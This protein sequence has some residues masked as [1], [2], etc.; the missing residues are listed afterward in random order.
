[1]QTPSRVRVLAR[2]LLLS[3]TEARMAKRIE[4]E[5][6]AL[7]ATTDEVEFV[8]YGAGKSS[9]S[10]SEE[11][12]AA[13]VTVRARIGD[14][15][16]TAS[17]PRLQGRFLFALL[18]DLKPDLCLELG[19][20]LGVST[21]YMTSALKLNDRGFA[22]SIEGAES[23]AVEARALMGRLALDRVEIDVGRFVDVLPGV[24]DG[25]RFDFA[26]V[27]GHHDE[28][29][30]IGYFSQ[31]T[32]AMTASG[33]MLFDDIAW[34]DGMR[35][36]WKAIRTDSAVADSWEYRGMGLVTLHA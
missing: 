33:V 22:Y 5:R 14:V 29:A 8:D 15:C 18:R 27:D 32:P 4:K 25:K 30:T 31:I 36:A 28:Q 21:A 6:R 10:R 1:M 12:M 19:T 17:K 3:P 24:L 9:D 11:E 26:F 13:G 20:C 34:S 16:R 7:E 2:S 35:R 23:L